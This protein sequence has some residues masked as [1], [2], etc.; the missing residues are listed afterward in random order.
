MKTFDEF[1]FESG[2]FVTYDDMSR[3]WKKEDKEEIK[4]KAKNGLIDKLKYRIPPKF[5]EYTKYIESINDVSDENKGIKFEIKLTSGD[6]LHAFRT[7]VRYNNWYWYLNKKKIREEDI[8]DKLEPLLLT[9]YE[10]WKNNYDRLDDT[11]AYSDDHRAYMRGAQQLG[12]VIDLYNKLSP[13]DKKKADALQI[14]K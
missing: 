5:S 9:P 12:K 2:D 6:I 7:D 1:L 3:Y 13:S 10:L 4:E 8:F 14:K 11:Y